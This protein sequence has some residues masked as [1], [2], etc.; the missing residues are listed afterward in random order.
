MNRGESAASPVMR[1][2]SGNSASVRSADMLRDQATDLGD[3]LMKDVAPQSMVD[4][5]RRVRGEYLEMPG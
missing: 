4:L 5:I 1:Q 2:P 3:Y